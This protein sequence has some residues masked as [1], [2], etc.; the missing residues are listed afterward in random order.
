M[1]DEVTN[2]VY[3]PFVRRFRWSDFPKLE[4][5]LRDEIATLE[6]TKKNENPYLFDIQIAVTQYY[7]KL[8]IGVKKNKKEEAPQGEQPPV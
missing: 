4:A 8:G 1:K 6:T 5:I 7:R 2:E 3:D